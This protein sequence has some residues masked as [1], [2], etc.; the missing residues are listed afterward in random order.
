MNEINTTTKEHS[1]NHPASLQKEL[2]YYFKP[3]T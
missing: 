1:K 2:T 3:Y